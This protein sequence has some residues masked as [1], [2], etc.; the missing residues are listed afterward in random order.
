MTW[1]YRTVVFCLALGAVSAANIPARQALSPE[2]TARVESIH[3]EGISL[4]EADRLDEAEARFRAAIEVDEKH[5][6]SY[7][8]LGHVLLERGD[9][10]AAEKAF[11]DALRKRK[12]H[13]PAYNGL[14]LVYRERENELRRAI[15]YFADAVRSDKTY[16]QAQ[17]NLAQTYQLYGSS[18]SLKAYRKVLKI[19]PR[20]PD[21]LFQIGRIHEDDR[22]H[23]KAEASYRE[24][25]EIR[26]EHFGARLH[27]A[28]VLKVTKRVDEA[29]GK[30]QGVVDV[31]NPHQRRALLELG[32]V[33]RVAKAF[34]RSQTLFE[35]YIAELEPKEQA[36]YYDLS[37][38]AG[39]DEL[40]RFKAAAQEEWRSLAEA[41]W[42]NHDPAPVTDANERFLEHCRRVAFA[43][44]HFGGFV[45]P[46][47]ARGEAYI[48]YGDP[49]HVSRSNNIR[50]ETN[51]KVLAVK[52]RLV[53]RAGE[54]GAALAVNRQ[55]MVASSMRAG[56]EHIAQDQRERSG[57]LREQISGS[58][59][60]GWPVYPV[61]G[62]WEYWIY[63]G[64][65]SGIEI[66]FVQRNHP[67]PYDY[68]D[69]P[70]GTGKIA[71]IWR[72]MNP[73][74][75]LPR[76]AARKPTTYRPD[77]ATGPLD[78]FYYSAAFK[79]Q[80]GQTNLEVYYGIPTRGVTFGEAPDGGQLARLS[81]GVAVH[82]EAGRQVHR[83]SRDISWR[84]EGVVDTS[85][86]LFVAE[87]DRIA[88]APGNYQVSVQVMD[89]TSG[90]TGIY[91]QDRMLKRY[92]GETLRLSDIELAS[93]IEVADK[94]RFLKDDILV[95]PLA[96]RSYLPGQ[97]IYIYYEIYNLARDEF[98]A[99]RYR[100]SY[101]VRSMERKSVGARILGGLGKLI[102]QSEDA[103]I[104][105]IQ[106]EHVGT[107]T[108]DRA[109]LELDMS[110]SE[111]GKQVLRV[112]VTDENTGKSA[113]AATTFTIG[114]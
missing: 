5:A 46:W 75:E 79:G 28:M 76:I 43:R 107:D 45:F 7:V 29:V 36:L 89:R 59:I 12:K 82:D 72:D 8:G 2:E 35:S 24:Q 91:K 25:L 4:L 70:M 27:L 32:D 21:A 55:D 41:F 60:L 13:A 62:V 68:V 90:K 86:G 92:E 31:P 33:Y 105:S 113:R 49:D 6:P 66:T 93:S 67:G 1:G 20:H 11:K 63:T 3:T 23:K 83:L 40:E 48:R 81:R 104:V 39:G 100:V 16:A 108:D 88:L 78:F 34:D 57:G 42:H 73:R 98:G 69:L 77:F 53:H 94:G 110:A 106:Y 96:S 51:P 18:E 15:R 84:S 44:E 109:Y 17:Y 87:M 74:V 14:G 61:D 58:A 85:A 54:A 52:D 37:L 9:L 102:G 114:R 101:E 22:D 80:D 95:V 71:Q 50:L 19:D 30:L 64:V 56:R 10:D 47:D 103:G 112:R 26:P 65:E 99:T 38:V 111:P 97:P